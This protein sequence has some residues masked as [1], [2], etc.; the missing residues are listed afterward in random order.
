MKT[1][2]TSQKTKRICLRSLMN[3]KKLRKKKLK[4]LKAKVRKY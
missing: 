4:E 1:Q 3:L 2:I